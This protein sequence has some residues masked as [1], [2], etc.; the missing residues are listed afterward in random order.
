M[1]YTASKSPSI[2]NLCR[3]IR[4][5]SSSFR[6]ACPATRLIYEVQDQGLA[7]CNLNYCRLLRTCLSLKICRR[8][9]L[10]Q[11]LACRSAS[12]FCKFCSRGKCDVICDT[13]AS[14]RKFKHEAEKY[15]WM[16]TRRV[17]SAG[18]NC[19]MVETINE[20]QT[21][22]SGPGCPAGSACLGEQLSQRQAANVWYHIVCYT[23]CESCSVF[24]LLQVLSAVPKANS[25]W[26]MRCNT[27]L[28]LSCFMLMWAG[29]PDVQE[30]NLAL[31]TAVGILEV[32][33]LSQI[34]GMCCKSCDTRLSSTGWGGAC[35]AR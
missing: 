13:S 29:D 3:L 10:L 12:T 21:A 23:Y 6:R 17:V 16:F 14:Q 31:G 34:W 26:G 32:Q 25:C 4:V 20:L 18:C 15:A 2:L 30:C 24:G 35:C 5:P 8:R 1:R 33:K 27:R 9:K 28:S 22:A 19:R 7:P 11:Y